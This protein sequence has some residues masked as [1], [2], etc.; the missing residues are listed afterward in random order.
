MIS[1]SEKD[2]NGMTLLKM[3]FSFLNKN[4]HAF[5]L[6]FLIVFINLTIF[7][8]F[9]FSEYKQYSI[10]IF[11]FTT[12]YNLLQ[13]NFWQHVKHFFSIVHIVFIAS[14]I[15]ITLRIQLI[16]YMVQKLDKK[17]Q[18]YPFFY[19]PSWRVIYEIVRI[20]TLHTV[21]ILKKIL[22]FFSFVDRANE[23]Q[24]LIIGNPQESNPNVFDNTTFL[25]FPLI[26]IKNISLKESFFESKNLL[27]KKF[28]EEILS[29]YS[30]IKFKL[31]IYFSLFIIIGGIIHF[32]LNFNI[33]P[34]MII[35]STA[36]LC[37]ASFIEN[38][39]LVLKA[40]LYNYLTGKHFEPFTQEEINKMFR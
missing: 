5:A 35:C 24:S 28:G 13:M 25:A 21:Q 29:N 9:L 37:F 26:I 23:I 16:H 20:A 6:C 4:K 19:I 14:F 38:V 3:C 17:Q 33:F 2:K 40:A 39:T 22:N 1:L 7:L 10:H 8:V 34:T 15:T 18:K 27:Q 12:F 36:I 31:K 11:D 32:I 30:L